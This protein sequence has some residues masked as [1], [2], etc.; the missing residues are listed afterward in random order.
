MI[1][2]AIT[3]LYNSLISFLNGLF[4]A[5]FGGWNWQILFSWLPQ[6]ILTAANGFILVCFG[7]ALIK[8]LRDL[9]PF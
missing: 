5:I 7:I 4:T 8:I 1:E 3:S 2:Q 9:L 6:D